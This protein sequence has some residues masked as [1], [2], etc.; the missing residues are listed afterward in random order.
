M[1]GRRKGVTEQ[2]RTADS[3]CC[4]SFGLCGWL[5]ARH[6]KNKISYKALPLAYDLELTLW[7]QLSNQKWTRDLEGGLSAMFIENNSKRTLCG[8]KERQI[9]QL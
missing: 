4:Y 6:P 2:S 3:C 7:N 1:P 9:E 5:I 8:R